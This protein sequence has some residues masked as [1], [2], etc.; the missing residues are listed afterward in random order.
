[1]I[2]ICSI[3]R[4]GRYQKDVNEPDYTKSK[5]MEQGV[6]KTLHRPSDNSVD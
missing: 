3:Y 4:V 1:M 2:R 6:G 5:L